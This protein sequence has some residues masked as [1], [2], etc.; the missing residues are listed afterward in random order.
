MNVDRFDRGEPVAKDSLA[1]IVVSE[2]EPPRYG[3]PQWVQLGNLEKV[4]HGV[5]GR[6]VDYQG[7]WDF[8]I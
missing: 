5:G 1:K 2:R 4:Q 8:W 7:G 3:K 6:Y